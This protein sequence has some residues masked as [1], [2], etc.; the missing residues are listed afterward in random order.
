MPKAP[1][2]SKIAALLHAAYYTNATSTD[3]IWQNAERLVDIGR[4]AVSVLRETQRE[5]M[6][7]T[8]WYNLYASVK[9]YNI[10]IPE[11]EEKSPEVVDVDAEHDDKDEFDLGEDDKSLQ[12]QFQHVN[13]TPC[14]FDIEDEPLRVDPPPAHSIRKPP[15]ERKLP[16]TQ[17]NNRQKLLAQQ[18]ANVILAV[19][20]TAV[21]ENWDA[22]AKMPQ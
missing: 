2:K 9:M 4:Q 11:E 17:V 5:G 3:N 12:L 6:Q 14:I 10:P 13:P 18:A 7:S 1:S 21:P 19:R 15:K 22:D 8:S 20:N 16:L